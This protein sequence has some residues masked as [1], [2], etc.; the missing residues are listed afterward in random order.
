VFNAILNFD[1]LNAGSPSSGTAPSGTTKA[2][3]QE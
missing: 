3:D 1:H 2:G